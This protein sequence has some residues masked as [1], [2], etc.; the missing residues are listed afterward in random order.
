MTVQMKA[1]TPTGDTLTLHLWW[2]VTTGHQVT[3]SQDETHARVLAQ[4]NGGKV[5]HCWVSHGHP[6]EA[7]S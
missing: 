6:R 1:T 2:K 4:E 7:T 3:F 5:T